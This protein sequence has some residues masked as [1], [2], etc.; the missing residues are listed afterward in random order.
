MPYEDFEKLINEMEALARKVEPELDYLA[1]FNPDEHLEKAAYM[2]TF[3]RW[4][5]TVKRLKE[6]FDQA[7]LQRLGSYSSPTKPD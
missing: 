7:T 1:K 5:D 4:A 2:A 3:V 6:E